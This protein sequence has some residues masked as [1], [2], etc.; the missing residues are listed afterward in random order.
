VPNQ[1]DFIQSR[2]NVS[3]KMNNVKPFGEIKVAPGL[4]LG[5]GS[6]GL[7]GYN[8]GMLDR[9]NWIDKSVDELRVN[10]KPKAS[11]LIALGR[12]GPANHFIKSQGALGKQE[13]NR[14]ET[15]AALGADRWFTTTGAEKGYTLVPMQTENMTTRN[16]T[17]SA[18]S[19]GAGSSV[20]SDYI[21]GE[22]MPTH[23]HALGSVPLPVPDRAGQGIAT[24]NDYS[25]MGQMS[26]M[27]N[28][29]ANSQ[30]GY[31]GSAGGGA[32]TEIIAPILDILRPSRKEN[33]IGT[34]RPYQ[35]AK[36]SV[37]QSY[38]FDPNDKPLTTIKET[39]INSKFHLHVNANQRGGGYESTEYQ[40]IENQ[41]DTTSNFSYIG[42]SSASDRAKQPM[43]YVADY[44][45]YNNEIKSSVIQNSG[46]MQQG[47]MSLLQTDMNQR[48]NSIKQEQFQNNRSAAPNLPYNIGVDSSSL[49]SVRQ[50]Q[51][52]YSNQ[53]L[54]R[55]NGD[56]L[57]Q[58][59]DNP[60]AQ[61]ILSGAIR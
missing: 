25:M 32:I 50:P 15:T 14:P 16:D 35:N 30:K 18:Y 19:G 46:R 56:V 4:G 1:S 60:F 40:P 24:Q 34:M 26:Y 48:N 3:T 53:Q 45:Q 38:I 39:T 33:S 52:L 47:N 11:G 28:R 41:R 29:S 20:S 7:G 55:N 61:N 13:K 21:S 6:E 10:N 58:L 9:E 2:M 44:N 51:G 54:D 27:N 23:N 12:E 59:R 22:Y 37:T 42:N 57:G 5:A 43:S 8:S 31:F 17:T 36:P 49:G